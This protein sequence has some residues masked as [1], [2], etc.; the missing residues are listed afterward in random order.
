[1]E[2]MEIA[3]NFIFSLELALLF[4]HEMDAIHRQEWRMFIILKI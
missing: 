4:T 3:L 2:H 1:M